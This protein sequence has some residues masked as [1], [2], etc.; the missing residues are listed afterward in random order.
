MFRQSAP[1]GATLAGVIA[2][3]YLGAALFPCDVGSP[4][5]GS[6]RQTTHNLA[7]GIEYVGGAICLVA[8]G[9]NEP[10][11]LVPGV[12]VVVATLLISGRLVA[13]VRG[14]VQRISECCLFG[15]LLLALGNVRAA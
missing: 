10:M 6:F 8:L 11:F 14:L 15:G 3:G 2:I 9:R 1:E 12:V 13:P 5:Y 7:G 4:L